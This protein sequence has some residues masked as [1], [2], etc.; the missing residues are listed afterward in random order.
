[1]RTRARPVPDAA[2]ASILSFRVD[3]DI[4]SLGEIKLEAHGA[5][6]LAGL[7][8][9]ADQRLGL[10]GPHR[11]QPSLARGHKAAAHTREAAGRGPRRWPAPHACVL[12]QQLRAPAAR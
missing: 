7:P 12:P 4:V 11:W 8:G 1:M 6:T 5:S 10:V 3:S 2:A 9:A